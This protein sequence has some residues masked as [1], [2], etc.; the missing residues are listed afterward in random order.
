MRSMLIVVAVAGCC[1]ANVACDNSIANT[2]A[3][4]RARKA[5]L[6]P[7]ELWSVEALNSPTRSKAVLI[8]ADREVRDGFVQ[9]IPMVGDRGCVRLGNVVSTAH[10]ASYRCVLNDRQFAVWS[11]RHGDLRRDFVAKARVESLE[12]HS[13][14]AQTLHFH[15][16]GACPTGWNVGDGTDQR[17]KKVSGTLQPIEMLDSR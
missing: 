3:S 12:D 17:G 15:R 10:G 16:V 1:I 9:A 6:D 11:E 8:C 7:A 4:I 2:E 14:Y 13:A 5:K